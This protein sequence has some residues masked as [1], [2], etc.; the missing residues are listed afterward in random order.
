[1]SSKC[2]LCLKKL[3]PKDS[4]KCTQPNCSL[5]Y[6]VLCVG[7]ESDPDAAWSCPQ[8]SNKGRR[9]PDTERLVT[10]GKQTANPQTT[11]QQTSDATVGYDASDL[12]K[13]SEDI[14]KVR[15]QLPNQIRT[16]VEAALQPLSAQL[17]Q[18]EQSVQLLSDKH[19]EVKK[20]L[21]SQS[22]MIKTVQ[23]ENKSLKLTVKTLEDRLATLED[24]SM[25]QEQWSRL[26]NVEIVGVP[27]MK[28]ES[29]ISIASKLAE[30]AGLQLQP[31]EIEFAHR[32]QAKRQVKGRPR[33]I[34]VCFRKRTT[35]DNYLSALKKMRDLNSTNSI[36]MEGE[37]SAIFV[38][39]H[40][41]T[42]NK[43][44]LNKCKTIAK[45]EKGYQFVW[46][47][48]CRIYTRKTQGSPFILIT[49]ESDLNKI[50]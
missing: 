18:L 5:Q 26:Q 30:Y 9:R 2:G 50:V 7:T 46:I 23:T 33:A 43:T 1:M 39:E 17:I 27:E 41:T 32:V 4:L 37:P 48:N 15:N 38:N 25:K 36:G 19:D 13:L 28:D 3:L 31:D 42:R 12:V 10:P 44:L 24:T 45:K 6:H 34:I 20:K 22:A 47:K 29:L 14:S 16:A 40:L 8:C 49:K 21:E 11:T 35:K